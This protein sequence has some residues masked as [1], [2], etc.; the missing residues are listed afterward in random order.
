MKKSEMTYKDLVQ[1]YVDSSSMDIIIERDREG[2]RRLRFIIK[3]ELEI[4]PILKNT[5]Q[6]AV[7]KGRPII[8]SNKDT[9]AKIAALDILYRK[10]K[11]KIEQ[12]DGLS[13]VVVLMSQK[14]R[15]DRVSVQET[16]QDWLEPH[17]KSVGR[18]K[19]KSRDRGWGVGIYKTDRDAIGMCFRQSDIAHYWEGAEIWVMKER[20]LMSDVF[21]HFREHYDD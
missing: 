7:V 5:K 9:K 21:S 4:L 19:S 3:G 8:T 16:I 18:T 14:Q 6:M 2:W 11:S 10:H 12:Y 15:A 13:V 20:G 17:D 1:H